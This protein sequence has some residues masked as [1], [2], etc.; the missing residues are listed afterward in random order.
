MSKTPPS[1][2][3]K[4]VID[5]I[6]EIAKLDASSVSKF[7]LNPSESKEFWENYIRSIVKAEYLSDDKYSKKLDN[8]I[9]KIRKSYSKPT[10]KLNDESYF[11]LVKSFIRVSWLVLE[12]CE[13]TRF[14][15]TEKQEHII[16][17]MD[18]RLR[19]YGLF[20]DI[21]FKEDRQNAR[22]WE[23]LLESVVE[24]TIIDHRYVATTE[25]I[26]RLF[27]LWDRLSFFENQENKDFA[28]DK[29]LFSALKIKTAVLLNR[30]LKDEQLGEY[31]FIMN[32]DT[33]VKN[34]IESVAQITVCDFVEK[35]FEK[36]KENREEIKKINKNDI[37]DVG[38]YDC[39]IKEGVNQ[40]YEEGFT[41][42]TKQRPNEKRE[43]KKETSFKTIDDFVKEKNFDSSKNVITCQHLIVDSFNHI[44]S[45]TEKLIEDKEYD[46]IKNIGENLV[47]LR[48]LSKRL[49]KYI[50]MHET[51]KVTSFRPPF[52]KSFY[53]IN[54]DNKLT[55][56]EINEITKENK[57]IFFASAGLEP[58]KIKWLEN[59]KH[60][61]INKIRKL[62]PDYY[63]LLQDKNVEATEKITKKQE[64]LDEGQK[65]N[66]FTLGVFAGLITF[67]TA[68]VAFFRFN[69]E[70][71]MSFELLKYYGIF[72][73]I[74]V[75]GL[76]VFAEIL[77]KPFK[78]KWLGQQ[79]EK[80]KTEN[81][82]LESKLKQKN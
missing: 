75:T 42:Y 6:T 57:I 30:I 66:V 26:E 52:K 29:K 11:Y 49:Q 44:Y 41:F 67:V 77:R 18:R 7:S 22:P 79:I 2:H 53:E 28:L 33:N 25:N 24:M 9:K 61:F 20:T 51:N 56:K 55:P 81:K 82:Q 58:I 60:E 10:S 74:L 72:T 64:Q 62:Y 32:N 31:L 5:K 12:L 45:K 3:L 71:E 80:L 38:K 40:W 21:T 14:C 76:W 59:Q 1:P 17:N 47:L 13:R 70:I 15:I 23:R 68:S 65:N 4:A 63:Q 54:T 37:T 78:D 19:F 16:V 36:E 46:S 48:R 34:E 35:R 39:Y 43:F 50:E 69:P 27:R 73:L 8:A